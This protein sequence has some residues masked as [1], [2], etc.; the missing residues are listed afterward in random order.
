MSL[1]RSRSIFLVLWA[2][3]YLRSLYRW[4]SKTLK[5]SSDKSSSAFQ[6]NYMTTSLIYP[7]EKWQWE[8][9]GSI[10][11]KFC[12]VLRVMRNSTASLSLIGSWNTLQN[13]STNW[14]S[15]LAV[16]SKISWANLSLSDWISWEDRYIT[17][18]SRKPWETLKNLHY[19][20]WV[21]WWEGSGTMT[22]LG[23]ISSRNWWKLRLSSWDFC[24]IIFSHVTGKSEWWA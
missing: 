20:W 4:M 2:L 19:I 16:S 1:S 22:E 5:A 13:K 17:H 8:Q 12:K 15:A 7:G 11:F 10:C 24:W 18:S 23:I 6:A 9:A 3:L 21:V 14:M